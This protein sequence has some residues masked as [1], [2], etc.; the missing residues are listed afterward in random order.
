MRV[1]RWIAGLSAASLAVALVPL[2]AA[3]DS[4]PPS[5]S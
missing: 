3:A 4:L 2:A 1:L 5:A